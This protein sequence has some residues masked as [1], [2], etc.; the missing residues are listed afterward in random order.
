M[1]PKQNKKGGTRWNQNSKDGKKL[2][3]L[4]RDNKVDRHGRPSAILHS[5]GWQGKYSTGTFRTAFHRLRDKVVDAE[6]QPMNTAA[7]NGKVVDCRICV[8]P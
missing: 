5:L 4:L 3:R 6:L 1:P 7:N 8:Y 2:Y